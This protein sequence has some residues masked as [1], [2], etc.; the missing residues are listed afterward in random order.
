VG[1]GGLEE[2]LVREGMAYLGLEGGE[3]RHRG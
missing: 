3:G 1:E 2:L